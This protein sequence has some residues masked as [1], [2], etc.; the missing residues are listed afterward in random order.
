MIV[1]SPYPKLQFIDNN[2]V[3]MANCLL[4]TY[5]AG[6]SNPLATFTD[7]TGSS[8]NPNPIVLDA[9][10]RANVWL[11]SNLSYKYILKNSDGS[12]LFTV[13]NINSTSD[14]TVISCNTI[15]DLKAINTSDLSNATANVAGY[16]VANDGGGGEFSFNSSS[17]TTDDGGM[18]IAPTVGTGRW[19]RIAN[20]EIN[21]LWY[22]AYS[23]GIQNDFNAFQSANAYA[24]SAGW[25]LFVPNGVFYLASNPS[26][27]VKV[28]FDSNAQLKWSNYSLQLDPIITDEGNHFICQ[29]TANVTFSAN[30]TEIHP[31]WFGAKGD[32]SFLNNAHGTDDTTAIQKT[33]D[34]CSVGCEVVFSS[35]KKYWSDTINPKPGTTIKGTQ[36]FEIDADPSPANDF[37]ANLQYISSGANFIETSNTG[38]GGLRGVKI[39]DLI[40]D[41]SG[42]ATIAITLETMNSDIDHCTI[43]NAATGISFGGTTNASTGNRIESCNIKNMTVVGITNAGVECTAGFINNINFT[44]CLADVGLTIQTNWIVSNV[45]RSSGSSHNVEYGNIIYND[46]ALA[47]SDLAFNL[48]SSEGTIADTVPTNVWKRD[49]IIREG[50]SVSFTNANYHDALTFDLLNS[51]PR[52]DTRTW[53]EKDLNGVHTW[54]DQNIQYGTL[55]P[56]PTSGNNGILSVG[57]L[58]FG[59]FGGN[60]TLTGIQTLMMGGDN[61][62]WL[63]Y[64]TLLNTVML[65]IVTY[66][67]GHYY[68][69]VY[70]NLAPVPTDLATTSTWQKALGQQTVNIQTG[71]TYQPGDFVIIASV[72]RA[73]WL[74]VTESGGFFYTGWSGQDYLWG[75]VLAYNASTGSITVNVET[76]HIAANTNPIVNAHIFGAFPWF[77]NND[78]SKAVLAQQDGNI[79]SLEITPIELFWGPNETIPN[80]TIP[81]QVQNTPPGFVG[82]N[83]VLIVQST[84]NGTTST[85]GSPVPPNTPFAITAIPNGGHSFSSW[86]VTYGQAVI[87]SPTSASTTVTLTSNATITAVFV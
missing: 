33:F 39:Q 43:R 38:I 63:L 17:T 81:L 2:G 16:Y 45:I 10:G 18:I 9:G 52:V 32:G 85:S 1:L 28:R 59:G 30:I 55:G 67:V 65:N 69:P 56:A 42:S 6:T 29:S 23:D 51:T 74:N 41:G 27:T 78:Q 61:M 25:Q 60:V 13:D 73:T 8:S 7:S 64:Q 54:G 49:Y 87:A 20:S 26:L 37:N 3:P 80:Q 47:S 5:E 50:S 66:S 31:E 44:N 19:Y 83:F 76:Y 12:I 40:I 11:D 34:S 77:S 75:E 72:S 68:Y 53:Y 84:P 15:A 14:V 71:Q 58:N 79:S 70:R 4:F 21:V 22:G 46:N 57:A 36:S 86:Q 48:I 24:T 62:Y 35:T 82:V